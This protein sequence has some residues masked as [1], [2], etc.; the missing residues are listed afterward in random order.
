MTEKLLRAR[1]NIICLVQETLIS[2]QDLQNRIDV[3][4]QGVKDNE[5]KLE[6]YQKGWHASVDKISKGSKSWMLRRGI[7]SHEED[8]E[9]WMRIQRL[10]EENKAARLPGMMDRYNKDVGRA[11]DYGAYVKGRGLVL[12]GL[13]VA[14]LTAV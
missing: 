10:V 11:E 1:H 13:T 12:T 3:A 4:D 2:V 5:A 14:M 7:R 9:S 8:I 6:R